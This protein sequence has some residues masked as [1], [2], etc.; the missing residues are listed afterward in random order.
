MTITPQNTN[1][2]GL[3]FGSG[4]QLEGDG[5][6]LIVG[7]DVLV[8]CQQSDGV[9][10]IQNNNTV[11]NNG[12]ILSG[13]DLYNAISLQSAHNDTHSNETITN[14][15]GATISGVGS[16]IIVDH[17]LGISITNHGSIN[18]FETYSLNLILDYTPGSYNVNNDG[19][20]YANIAAIYIDGDQ[21]D[22]HDLGRGSATID[23]TGT[24][25]IYGRGQGIRIFDGASATITNQLNATISSDNVAIYAASDGGSFTLNNAGHIVNGIASDATANDVVVNSGTITGLVLLGAGDDRYQGVGSGVVTGAI[26][27]GDGDD[28]FIADRARETFFGDAGANTFVYDAVAFSPNNANHDTIGDFVSGN[29]DKIDVHGI[30]ANVI[31]HGHQHFAFIGTQ[32]FAHYHSHHPSVIGMLRFDAGTHALEGNVNANFHNAEF[33]VSMPSTTTLQASDLIL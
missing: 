16:G 24:G 14:N 23:N 3:V 21:V 13:S 5:D 17:S 30:D 7:A 1:F 25:L 33:L 27:G 2:Y 19:K 31:R 4:F 6:E 9:F 28:T 15:F 18:G 29:G 8:G 10:S 11:V 22:L 32:S 26:H 12:T 20:I